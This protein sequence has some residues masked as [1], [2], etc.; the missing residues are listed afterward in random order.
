MGGDFAL[1]LCSQFDRNGALSPRQWDCVDN[2]LAKASRPK[3]VLDFAAILA[4]FTTAAANLKF[5]KVALALADGS[6]VV[7]SR[8]GN[9][10]RRPGTINITNGGRYQWQPSSGYDQ[11]H[12]RRTLRRAG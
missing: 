11:H 10:S 1:S 7:L 12:K 6:A 9:R 2:M 5:P 8:A 4:I 3:I